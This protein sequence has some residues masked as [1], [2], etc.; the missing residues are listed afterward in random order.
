MTFIHARLGIIHGSTKFMAL[1]SKS[2]L[3]ML[4]WIETME[5]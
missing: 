2:Y 4:E 3:P 5:K 1:R